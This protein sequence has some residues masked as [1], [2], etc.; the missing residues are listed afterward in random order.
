MGLRLTLILLL[1]TS[2]PA[3]LV[4]LPRSPMVLGSLWDSAQDIAAAQGFDLAA[5]RLHGNAWGGVTIE[6]LRLQGPGTDLYS[7]EARVEY[8]LL[9]P[10]T[11]ILTL[12]AE[13]SGVRGDFDPAP[14]VERESTPAGGVEL[15]INLQRLTLSDINIAIAE[16]ELYLPAVSLDELEVSSETD[17]LLLA[18]ALSPPDG[19]AQLN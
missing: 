2:V 1:V 10:L 7:A 5:D 8:G 17:R 13:L 4:L 15:P 3:M 16:F 19:E 18:G 14:L 6:G 12:S 9:S 11:G